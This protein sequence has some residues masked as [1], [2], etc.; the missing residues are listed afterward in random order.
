MPQSD[1]INPTSAQT[2]GREMADYLEYL[3][4]R[5]MEKLR[6]YDLDKAMALAEESAGISEQLAQTR[7]LE[8]PDMRDQQA[9]IQKLYRQISLTIAAEQQEVG[10]K[11]K[12][13]RKCL[14]AL[15]AYSN[16]SA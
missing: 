12:A 16:S 10:D 15:G 5:Q 13:I 9:R 6:L 4:N 14:N 1:A 2:D 8:E 7:L 3:L 11:L